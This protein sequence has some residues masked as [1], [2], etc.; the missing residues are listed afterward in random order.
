MRIYRYILPYDGGTA[1]N[2]FDGVCTLAICKPAIR[3][4]AAIGDWIMGFHAAPMERG[5]V[6]YAM[7]VGEILTFAKYWRDPRFA[8]RKPSASNS[9]PDNIYKSARHTD[10]T[11]SMQQVRNHVHDESHEKRDISGKRVLVSRRFWY[12]GKSSVEPDKR[13]PPDLM[14]LA[15][16]TE[17]H[18]V[19]AHRKPD[20]IQCVVEWLE[21]HP[22]GLQGTP[23]SKAA[24][25]ESCSPCSK[26][27]K[28]VSRVC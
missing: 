19:D 17:G 22:A 26:R 23:Q 1:P 2:P 3:R 12:F 15:P 11:Q 21:Q 8:T 14:H 20:D 6:I 9:H 13:L 28:R 4:T 24:H 25:G 27:A 18:V 10:G 16:A 5:H 7:Q